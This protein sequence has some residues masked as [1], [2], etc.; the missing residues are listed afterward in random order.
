MGESPPARGWGK[1]GVERSFLDLSLK[2]EMTDEVE[3]ISVLR[4]T[5]D[6]KNTIDD[7]VVKEFPLTIV[8]D[9]QE[10]VTMLCSPAK[11][12]Y[13][14]AG[15]LLS[16]GLIDSKS[17]IGNVVV[18]EK[19][20]VVRVDTREDKGFAKEL[21]FK[22]IITS[23]CGRGAA[24]YSAADAGSMAKVESGTE[25]A[26]QEVFALVKEFQQRSEIFRETGGVHS[27]ALC[28]TKNI[29]VFSED[30]GRHNAIDKIFGEC[31]MEDISTEGR[32]IVTSGRIS[33]EILLK[34]AKRK[35]PVIISKSAPTNLSLR[36]ANQLGV[37]LVGFVR[38]KRMNVYTN[39]WRVVG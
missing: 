20:G 7:V 38:G 17:E 24:F 8:L 31:M 35:I 25:I 13:L 6:G 9:N 21:L 39:D 15:F 2:V 27:A 22:R 32:V 4:I 1:K 14:A 26:A 10:L 34:V 5:E 23:G 33:S 18:D 16:E 28:D 30:I 29:L 3:K 36:L 37:T 12:K 19:R 11:L